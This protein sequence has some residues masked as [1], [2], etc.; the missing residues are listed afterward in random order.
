MWIKSPVFTFKTKLKIEYKYIMFVYLALDNS[1][2][3][4]YNFRKR[5]CEYEVFTL[6][7]KK[8]F[9]SVA[10]FITPNIYS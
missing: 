1:K 8:F 7:I 9:N 10:M 3:V 6:Y 5:E 2:E 4:C